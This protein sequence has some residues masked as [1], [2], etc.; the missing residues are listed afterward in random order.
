[1]GKRLIVP[2]ASSKALQIALEDSETSYFIRTNFSY[3]EQNPKIY[4]HKWIS[5]NGQRYKWNIEIIEKFK[6]SLVCEEELLNIALIEVDS[7]SGKII[8]RQYLRNVLASE[9]KRFLRK[10]R[11]ADNLA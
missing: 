1:L 11:T 9:Y 3:P 10:K 7:N 6:L 5:R 8:K 2:I 4:S